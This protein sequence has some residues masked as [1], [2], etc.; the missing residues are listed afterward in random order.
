MLIFT[1]RGGHDPKVR[2]TVGSG[3]SRQFHNPK[4]D[5][6]WLFG[7]CFSICPWM[8]NDADVWMD[9]LCKMNRHPR[10]LYQMSNNA[11]KSK[12]EDIISS[13]I[14]YTKSRIKLDMYSKIINI[15]DS[16]PTN[17]YINLLDSLKL[18]TKP[19]QKRG[20][21]QNQLYP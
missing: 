12:E 13:H 9:R 20:V 6:F 18:T 3:L 16:L 8:D 17:I 5:N 1:T 10:T 4:S 11:L 19:V 21:P 7:S 15:S 2:G 14:L